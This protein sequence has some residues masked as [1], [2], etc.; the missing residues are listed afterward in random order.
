MGI[1]VHVSHGLD[2]GGGRGLHETLVTPFQLLLICLVALS[3]P[4]DRHARSPAHHSAPP[5]AA[6][7][8]QL[9]QEEGHL[10]RLAGLQGAHHVAQHSGV[11]P[12]RPRRQR[13]GV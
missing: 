11:P 2:Q 10:L 4:T 12:R 13:D 5:P 9:R 3:P 8:H 6:R 7:L 1:H